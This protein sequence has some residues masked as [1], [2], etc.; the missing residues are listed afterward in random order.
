MKACLSSLPD[1]RNL[2]QFLADETERKISRTEL[3]RIQSDIQNEFG[4]LKKLMD[5]K[6]ENDKKRKAKWAAIG[7]GSTSKIVFAVDEVGRFSPRL[8]PVFGSDL[9]VD[10][11]IRNT[12]ELYKL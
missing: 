7:D 5:I 12:G 2:N 4:T 8:S 1:L 11:L 10:P 6:E 3:S 9:L